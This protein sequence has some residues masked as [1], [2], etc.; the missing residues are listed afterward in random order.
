VIE[1]RTFQ[2]IDPPALV[3]LWRSQPAQRGLLASV[4]HADLEDHVFSKPYFDP[5]GLVI[6]RRDHQPLGFAHAA[7]GPSADRQRLDRQTGIIAMV[8]TRDGSP[9]HESVVRAL[10]DHCES[11]LREHSAKE[12]F[13]PCRF[14]YGPF[15][16]GLY[17]GS[18]IPGLLATEPHKIAWFLAAGYEKWAEIDV[19]QLRMMDFRPLVDRRQA[20]LRRKLRVD[21]EPDPSPTRWWDA[22]TLGG[23]DRTRFVMVDRQYQQPVGDVTF[24]DILPLARQW[25]VRSMGIFDL[26]IDAEA[27][28]GGLATF[29]VTEALRY[30]QQQGVALVEAQVKRTNQAAM[31]LFTKLGFRSVDRGVVMRK[32]L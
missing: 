15:Y 13:V 4:T 16:L 1:L 20:L 27:R 12:C 21:A 29:L 5:R 31:G 2:N 6:A 25:G 26:A 14:P 30:M 22:C 32:I 17:G 18:Q 10:V 28:K 19:L 11:Y 8:M 23:V 24:W 9:E 3:E 7:F